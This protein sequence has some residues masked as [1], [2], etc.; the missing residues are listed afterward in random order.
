MWYD[1]KSKIGAS[2]KRNEL[3]QK[4]DDKKQKELE[5]ERQ[6]LQNQQQ[7]VKSSAFSNYGSSPNNFIRHTEL[8]AP[9]YPSNPIHLK[10]DGTPDYRDKENR[11]RVYNMDGTRDRRYK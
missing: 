9:N 5:A 1:F 3:R 6:R 7:A 11:T 2:I 4:E 10:K 8:S